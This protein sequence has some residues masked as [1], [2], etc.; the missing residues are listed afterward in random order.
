MIKELKLNPCRVISVLNPV[1]YNLLETGINETVDHPWF[2]QVRAL[3]VI[4]F[5][6]SLS[7]RKDV[8]TCIKAFSIALNKI[9]ANLYIIGDGPDRKKYEQLVDSLG[10]TANV[11]FAGFRV[12]PFKFM[13]HC[14]LFLSTSKFEGCPNAI[15]QAIASG[16]RVLATDEPG[17]TAE[18]LGYGKF[19]TL[20]EVGDSEGIASQ[21]LKI[22]S[23]RDTNKNRLSRVEYAKGFDSE[24][25]Y[26]KYYNSITAIIE[27]QG[28]N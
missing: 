10:I 28:S 23:Q 9:E 8:S 1:D 27:G 26:S 21:M 25:A 22:L 24:V 14:D 2:K 16:A 5:V 15:Q 20:V 19:G 11:E 7:Q 3:P 18:I 17:G 12:N 6:G 13:A 4:C